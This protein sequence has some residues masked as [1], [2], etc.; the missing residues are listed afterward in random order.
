MGSGGGTEVARMGKAVVVPVG[1]AAGMATRERDHLVREDLE[2]AE[3]GRVDQVAVRPEDRLG[4]VQRH[5]E[6]RGPSAQ[7]MG[8]RAQSG[9][10]RDG[11]LPAAGA[12][13]AAD[14]PSVEIRSLGIA[15]IL[16]LVER[17]LDKPG[18]PAVVG[19]TGTMMPSAR[20]IR[21]TSARAAP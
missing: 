7:R 10:G 18:T 3:R 14:R 11:G 21:S 8:D 16:D 15:Q 13:D 1:G 19:G 2:L 4:G 12:G 5:A 20:P 9:Q 17:V 6:R